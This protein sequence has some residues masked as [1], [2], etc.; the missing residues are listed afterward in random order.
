M[1]I[2]TDSQCHQLGALAEDADRF[3]DWPVKSWDVLR[4]IGAPGWLIP[5]EYGGAGWTA[6]DLLRGM[7]QIAKCCLTT[8][9]AFSQRE[10]AIRHL[11]RS[12]EH[13]KRR[14]LP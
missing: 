11:L 10:A 12:P 3:T 2:L 5:A 6:V 4:D 13:L 1:D 14:Y 7:E 8:A 9:F